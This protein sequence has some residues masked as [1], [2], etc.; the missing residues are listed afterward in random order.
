MFIQ[1]QIK[2]V[3]RWG[4]NRKRWGVCRSMFSFSIF[5]QTASTYCLDGAF[6]TTFCKPLHVHTPLYWSGFSLDATLHGC[7][8]SF[9]SCII[10]SFFSRLFFCD[11]SF[12]L[13]SDSSNSNSI[14]ESLSGK[15][16]WITSP[17]FWNVLWLFAEAVFNGNKDFLN[18]NCLFC[19]A[20][21]FYYSFDLLGWCKHFSFKHLNQSCH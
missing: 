16:P 11:S 1:K 21:S 20:V 7:I 5:P 17:V 18:F 15:T 3:K 8:V 4:L 13:V 6:W 2:K 14:L 19:N 9:L 12:V 10:N